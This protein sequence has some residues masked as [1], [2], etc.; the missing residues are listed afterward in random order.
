MSADL[1]RF[2][3]TAE[4]ARRLGISVRGVRMLIKRGRLASVR[5]GPGRRGCLLVP[6]AALERLLAERRARRLREREMRRLA[7]ARRRRLK[8]LERARER[9]ARARARAGELRRLLAE[10]EL[11]RTVAQL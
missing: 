8:R 5:L 6:E 7:P 10:A 9:L 3:R 2:V 11:R 4:A 1:P